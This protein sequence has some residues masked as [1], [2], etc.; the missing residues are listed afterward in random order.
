MPAPHD[1]RLCSARQSTSQRPPSHT[2]PI[3]MP[4]PSLHSCRHVFAHTWPTAAPK[5]GGGP[6]LRHRAGTSCTILLAVAGALRGCPPLAVLVLRRVGRPHSAF[7]YDRQIAHL[8]PARRLIPAVPPGSRSGNVVPML[9]DK[10]VIAQDPP[11]GQQGRRHPLCPPSRTPL[12]LDAPD[13]AA[14]QTAPA[15]SQYPARH[16][17]PSCNSRFQRTESTSPRLPALAMCLRLRAIATAIARTARS[18]ERRLV[19]ELLFTH[20]S[21]AAFFRR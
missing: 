13:C 5:S 15:P 2:R 6:W 9:F 19:A 16:L 1:S 10:G 12:K 17:G 3:G 7:R 18:L 8:I 11:D 14:G 21:V 20:S 4:A